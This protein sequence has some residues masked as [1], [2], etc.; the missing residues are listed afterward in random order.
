M[1]SFARAA[2]LSLLA[3]LAPASA[4]A[5]QTGAPA[6][7]PVLIVFFPDWSGALD[8]AAKDVIKQA[9]DRAKQTPH[10]H[11]LVAGYA[12]STGGQ[13]AD[14]ALTQLR[15][16][17]VA[18]ALEHDGIPKS[19]ITTQAEGAQ[20]IHGVASRRVEITITGP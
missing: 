6:T 14:L 13:A 12:D 10:A 2:F 3:G 8:H 1:T 7:T 20:R 18:D 15:A 16:R 9:S 11:I 4:G 17:R 19:A 5:A